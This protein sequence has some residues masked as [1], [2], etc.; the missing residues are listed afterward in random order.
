M[1]N[2]INKIA[3]LLWLLASVSGCS[4]VYMEQETQPGQVAE[5]IPQLQRQPLTTSLIDSGTMERENL[6]ADSAYYNQQQPGVSETSFQEAYAK[7]KNPKIALFLYRQL[8]QDILDYESSQRLAFSADNKKD[9]HSN[10]VI[11]KQNDYNI[12]KGVRYLTATDWMWSFENQLIDD[13][14]ASGVNI[15]DRATVMRLV[16]ADVDVAKD[17]TGMLSGKKI[18]TDA[19]TGYADIFIEILA[20]PSKDYQRRYE[21]R[22]LAKRIDNGQLIATVTTLGRDTEDF[23]FSGTESI[24]NVSDNIEP[25]KRQI[26]NAEKAENIARW[27]GWEIR[28]KLVSYWAR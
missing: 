26:Q 18:E 4:T 19:L 12:D 9:G 22:A 11:A 21:Y 14:L 5:P 16:A 10:L 17:S 13:F 3:F 27:L 20:L 2:D 25:S 23:S 28:N 6:L 1:K 15:V 8:S 7:A 24:A